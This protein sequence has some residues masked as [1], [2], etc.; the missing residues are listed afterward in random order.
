MISK[1]EHA[2]RM[3][4]LFG[5]D[6]DKLV[7]LSVSKSC[8][9]YYDGTG[10]VAKLYRNSR[11]GIAQWRA[12]ETAYHRAADHFP[13]PKMHMTY[14]IKTGE[15]II[16][17]AY[18]GTDGFAMVESLDGPAWLQCA[19]ELIAGLHAMHT[20]GRVAHGD[21]KPENVAFDGAHWRFIDFGLSQVLEGEA[22]SAAPRRVSGTFPLVI[23]GGAPTPERGDRFALA[24]T[25]LYL[26]RTFY[27]DGCTLDCIAA[28]TQCAPCLAGE[29][30]TPTAFCRVNIRKMH[31]QRHRDHPFADHWGGAPLPGARDI[32][33]ALI[34]IV[35]AEVDP[36][37]AYLVWDRAARV[38]G[39]LGQNNAEGESLC[40]ED[41]WANLMNHI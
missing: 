26:G 11:S 38:H 2:A 6:P 39:Y 30:C 32:W 34:D 16:I 41:A 22:P 37:H 14:R 17:M 7:P 24:M 23:P 1:E 13:A 19:R 35:L 25:L 5:D 10:A 40:P 8:A 29:S 27:T 31:A 21:I 4:V 36:Q 9:V 18:A 28:P 12:E 33:M 15:A 3:R 20:C